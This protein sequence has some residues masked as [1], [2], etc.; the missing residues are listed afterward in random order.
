MRRY[1][2]VIVAAAAALLSIAWSYGPAIPDPIQDAA[3]FWA[4]MKAVWRGGG[5][6]PAVL[7]AAYAT[8]MALRRVV[9]WLRDGRRAAWTASAIGVLGAMADVSIGVGSWPSVLA[10]MASA[11]LLVQSP[12]GKPPTDPPSPAS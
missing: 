6:W 10:A 7:I 8:S 11:V 12:T 9:P 2:P 5:L 3:G 1:L 4:A